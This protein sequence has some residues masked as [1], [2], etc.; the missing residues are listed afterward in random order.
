MRRELSDEE[1]RLCEKNLRIISEREK[2][3]EY[4]ERYLDLMLSEGLEVNLKKQHADFR[5]QKK[6]I[7]DERMELDET[8]LVLSAQLR[9]GVEFKT[10]KELEQ[11]VIGESGGFKV[12]TSDKVMVGVIKIN[13]RDAIDFK[14]IVKEFKEKK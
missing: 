4:H 3:L 6:D 12:R 10:S 8:K 13:P 11:G 7:N 9:D 2:D 1:K 14:E 5:K